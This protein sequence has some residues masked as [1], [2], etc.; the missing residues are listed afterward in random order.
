MSRLRFY[1]GLFLITSCTLMLQ[2]IQTRILSVVAWYHLAFFAISMAM[3]GLTAGAVWVYLRGER[4]TEKT[5][6]YDLSYFST[7]F[8]VTTAL[9]LIIQMSLPLTVTLSVTSILTWVELA[10]CMSIPFSFSGVVVSLALTRSP[11]PIGRVYGVDLLGAAVGCLGVLLILNNTDGPSAVL[12]VG[13]IAAAGALFFAGSGVGRTPDLKPPFESFFRHRGTIFFVLVAFAIANGLTDYGLQPVVSKGGF[14]SGNSHIFREWN[15]FS[16][17]AV[18][19]TVEGRPQMWGPSPKMSLDSSR[20]EQR[21]MNIDGSD[22][23][24]IIANVKKYKV[25]THTT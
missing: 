11:F 15:T 22:L 23:E 1:I 4:F 6:S 19:P 12:W 10:L 25:L 3:F 16:R 13:A 8:A 21:S 18:Y 14:E 2:V 24:P 5:L 9:C 20:I 17:I 7:A